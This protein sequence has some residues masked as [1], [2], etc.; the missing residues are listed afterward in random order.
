MLKYVVSY[1]FQD[2]HD[3]QSNPTTT[4][5]PDSEGSTYN[6]LDTQSCSQQVSANEP[7]PACPP[8]T[9]STMLCII[10]KWC[11]TRSWTRTRCA[12]VTRIHRW[13]I[14]PTAQWCH[15]NP[16]GTGTKTSFTTHQRWL[17]DH[18]IKTDMAETTVL[19]M[20]PLAAPCYK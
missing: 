13:T 5:P 11:Q 10:T 2:S 20:K 1:K 9:L 4:P 16:R 8:T 7:S 6:D 15:F 14:A 18:K 19:L 17:G 12:M 3:I